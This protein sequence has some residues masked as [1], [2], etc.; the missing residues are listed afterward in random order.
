[1]SVIAMTATGGIVSAQ[2]HHD[3]YQYVLHDEWKNGARVSHDDWNRGQPVDYRR[4]TAIVCPAGQW[5]SWQAGIRKG[6]SAQCTSKP[7]SGLC[8]NLN[9]RQGGARS[10][11][12]VV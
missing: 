2:D 10:W 7:R 1:V 5:H 9:G 11:F 4:Y 8:I 3:N 12:L 6:L